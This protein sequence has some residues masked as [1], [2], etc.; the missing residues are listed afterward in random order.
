MNKKMLILAVLMLFTLGFLLF[1][2]RMANKPPKSKLTQPAKETET[3]ATAGA[4]PAVKTEKGT[5]Q[6]P[7][8]SVKTAQASETDFWGETA[9]ILEKSKKAGMP[10]YYHATRRDPMQPAFAYAESGPFKLMLKDGTTSASLTGV[11]L[12]TGKASAIINEKILRV[13]DMVDGKKIVAIEKNRVIL[14]KGTDEE[15]LRLE[16]N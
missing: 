3:G 9:T 5:G 15:I 6:T 4:A 16:N 10:L 7:D 8:Q 14:K 12:G 13:G 1:S 11:L 2:I